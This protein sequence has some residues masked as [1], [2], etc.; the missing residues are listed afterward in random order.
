MFIF[1]RYQ[2]ALRGKAVEC[3]ETPKLECLGDEEPPDYPLP[4]ACVE[5]D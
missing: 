1:V 5:G 3:N 4:S 2:L